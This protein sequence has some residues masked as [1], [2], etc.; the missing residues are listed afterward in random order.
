MANT[1]GSTSTGAGNGA[2]IARIVGL[3]CIAGFLADLL[4]VILP[5]GSGA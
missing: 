2:A 5:M 4:G 1:I 3:I